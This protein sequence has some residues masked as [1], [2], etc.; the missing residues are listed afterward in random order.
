MPA[1]RRDLHIQAGSF[2]RLYWVFTNPDTGD[3]IDLTAGYLA[4]GVVSAREDGHGTDYLTLT[5]DDFRR[6][7]TGRVYYEPSSDE[8]ATWTFRFAHYQFELT[9]PAGEDVRFSEG[10]F[11]VDPE[12]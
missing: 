1:I 3:L 12:I 6:T 10:R 2:E 7:A 11:L 9:H 8:T 5:D 4:S